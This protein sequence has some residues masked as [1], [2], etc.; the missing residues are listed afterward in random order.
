MAVP[1]RK[2]SRSRTRSRRAQWKTTTV[3][4]V[5]VTINGTEYRVPRPLVRAARRGLI[6]VEDLAPASTPTKGQS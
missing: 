1:K 2:K 3:D 5:P 4:L 6:D